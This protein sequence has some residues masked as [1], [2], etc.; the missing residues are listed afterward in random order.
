MPPCQNVP[1]WVSCDQAVSAASVWS[2]VVTVQMAEHARVLARSILETW[3][4]ARGPAPDLRLIIVEPSQL[5]NNTLAGLREAGWG[6]CHIEMPDYMK[7]M[8]RYSF[9]C[10][11]GQG[12]GIEYKHSRPIFVWMWKI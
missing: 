2:S 7:V 8:G 10:R 6:L 4:T 9:K 12:D 1:G 5:D 3:D 11:Q